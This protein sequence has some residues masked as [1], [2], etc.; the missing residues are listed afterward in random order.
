MG[1]SVSN[2]YS[3][4]VKPLNEA[5]STPAP[6]VSLLSN[7]DIPSSSKKRRIFVMSDWSGSSSSSLSLLQYLEEIISRGEQQDMAKFLHDLIEKSFNTYFSLTNHM[8][9]NLS[10][11][12]LRSAFVKETFQSHETIQKEGECPCSMRV[13]EKGKVYCS[14][15]KK[16]I[17]NLKCPVTYGEWL[18]DGGNANSN[19]DCGPCGPLDLLY[20]VASRPNVRVMTEA[21]TSWQLLRKDY[22]IITSLVQSYII[23]QRG[24][25]LSE[26]PEIAL[27]SEQ[28]LSKL[29][30]NVNVEFYKKGEVIGFRKR[31]TSSFKMIEKGTCWLE[32]PSEVYNHL[33]IMDAQA[34]DRALSI[35]RPE[36]HVRRRIEDMTVYQ[37]LEYFKY[38]STDCEKDA[39]GR[40][41]GPL[42]GEA[43]P[44]D[45]YAPVLPDKYLKVEAGCI[46]GID[47]LRSKIQASAIDF[48]KW[49]PSHF[50]DEMYLENTKADGQSFAGSEFPFSLVAK[51]DVQIIS[52]SVDLLDDLFTSVDLFAKGCVPEVL[53][54][55]IVSGRSIAE[56]EG[57]SK[58]VDQ[59][60]D[61]KEKNDKINSDYKNQDK[62]QNETKDDLSSDVKEI[63]KRNSNSSNNFILL[64]DTSRYYGSHFGIPKL[65]KKNEKSSSSSS[66]SD[67]TKSNGGNATTDVNKIGNTWRIKIYSKGSI[68][69]SEAHRRESTLLQK[70][71]MGR[72]PPFFAVPVSSSLASV[73][74]AIDLVASSTF[75]PTPLQLHLCMENPSARGDL[76]RLIH[77]TP[78][79][80]PRTTESAL[81]CNFYFVQTM[82]AVAHLHAMQYIFRGI[83]PENIGI[84]ARGNAKL[85]DLS[86]CAKAAHVYT[87]QGD[88]RRFTICGSPEYM[89]PEIIQGK[90]Y[91][92]GVDLW[93]LGVLLHELYWGYT[94]FGDDDTCNDDNTEDKCIKNKDNEIWHTNDALKFEKILLIATESDTILE[95]CKRHSTMGNPT[96]PHHIA[97]KL[98]LKLLCY[99]PAERCS[100]FHPMGVLH[101]LDATNLFDAL[102]LDILVKG[103][104]SA[105]YVIPYKF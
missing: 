82:V 20:D 19:L 64:E 50:T 23:K 24:I 76:W 61:S 29:V 21:A 4:A 100:L 43:I 11:D 93:A 15:N 91:G 34:I 56:N 90:G 30:Q 28:N 37:F 57:E 62:G 98:I 92:K 70:L 51:T 17:R 26:C 87:P 103:T 6:T 8:R 85:I 55:V 49:L 66:S 67:D 3:A 73:A 72:S 52:F 58:G 32:L 104:L 80:V 33:D 53:E 12:L 27:L 97:A 63:R 105:P 44:P 102:E 48:W 47:A 74:M 71:G 54:E 84:D 22:Q 38:F 69:E 46:M 79:G 77:D 16:C 60:P 99:R 83:C 101:L 5:A 41:K 39:N 65:V 35:L 68:V 45:P 94:P 2:F 59:N 7:I 1:G 75:L 31:L 13:F 25:W 40:S 96:D 18:E 9:C 88:G 36:G 95:T 89:A 86:T 78:D 14:L 10:I 81:L 42:P